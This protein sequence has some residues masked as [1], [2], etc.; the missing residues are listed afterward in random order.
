MTNG[1]D[2][3]QLASEELH[4][5][6]WQGI[7]GVSRTRLK[8]QKMCFVLQRIGYANV[9]LAPYYTLCTEGVLNDAHFIHVSMAVT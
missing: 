5:S 9:S 2:P 8:Q 6:Q 1:A 4:C 3:D 7:K